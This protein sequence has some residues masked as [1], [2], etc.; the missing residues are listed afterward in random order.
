MATTSISTNIANI[1][2]KYYINKA[3]LSANATPPDEFDKAPPKFIRS[4]SQKSVDVQNDTLQ[5]A[6]NV[7]DLTRGKTRLNVISALTKNDLVDFFKFN[8]TSDE[9]LGLAITT[10]KSLHV[11]LLK[12]NGQVIADSETTSGD[13]KD[14]FDKLASGSLDIK[15]GAYFIKVTRATGLSRDERPNYAIQI[16]TTR[17]YEADYDTTETPA[18]NQLPG[19]SA[20]SQGA[21]LTS[22]LL[23][24]MYS[25]LDSLGTGE[26]YNKQV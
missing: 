13:K 4:F 20:I 23:S 11:Q 12:A 17:Y 24:K 8:A 3:N 1:I 19:R 7:G 15:K 26:F 5:T 2:A 16:S 9:K 25:G 22:N 21:L 14:N 10:D 6:R 18:A